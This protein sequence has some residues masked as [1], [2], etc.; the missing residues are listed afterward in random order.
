MSL[1]NQKAPAAFVLT[2]QDTFGVS[3]RYNL[4]ARGD[5]YLFAWDVSPR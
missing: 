4:K 1:I 2:Y 3:N 5:E